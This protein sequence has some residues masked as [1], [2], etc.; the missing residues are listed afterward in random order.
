MK[1]GLFN[2]GG[3]AGLT[4]LGV[5]HMSEIFMMWDEFI[6]R[7]MPFDGVYNIIAM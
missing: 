1:I 7:A 5:E 2:G 3:D 6:Y 4:S